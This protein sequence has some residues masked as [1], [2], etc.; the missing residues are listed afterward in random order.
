MEDNKYG[1]SASSKKR[2]DTLLKAVLLDVKP[3][4]KE[5]DDSKYAINEVMAR[6]KKNSPK[7]VEILLA[8]SVARGTQIRGNSDIDIF[9]LFPRSMKE[10]IIEKKGL[11][12]GKSIVNKKKGESYIV[13]YAEHPYTRLLLNDLRINVDIVPAFKIKDSKERGT[14]VDRTQLHNEFVNQN[15]SEKQ[16]DEVRVLKAFLKAHNI[17]GAEAK[18]EGFSG[19]LCELLIYHNGSFSKLVTN[20]ANLE[21]PLVINT[22]SMQFD[23]STL[24]SIIK[25]FNH[26]LIVIDPTDSNR[27]VAAN[28][29]EESLLRFALVS[30]KLIKNPVKGMFYSQSYDEANSETKLTQLRSKLNADIYAIYFKV[31]NIAQ[32]IIWQQTKKTRLRL[33]SLLKENGFEPILSLQYTKET[34]AI[35]AFFIPDIKINSTKVTGPSIEMVDAVEKFMKSHK[36]SILTLIDKDRIYS[37]EKSKYKNPEEF[38]RHFLS[39]KSTQLPSNLKAKNA[40]LHINKIPEKHARM[41]YLAHW[42]KTNI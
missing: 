37:I 25:K 2:L 3:S 11:E 23:K 18:T 7:D 27:N 4:K 41:L 24:S 29:S 36:N 15:L 5:I 39:D 33:E 20:I 16:R 19:Y 1:L 40:T 30:R 22:A 17:Y 12:I 6:L 8:G 13:K 32:D 35:M 28:V 31:P 26:K 42:E 21:L 10:E 38:I 34:D 14:A 9:L